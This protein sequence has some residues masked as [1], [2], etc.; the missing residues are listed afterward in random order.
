MEIVGVHVARAVAPTGET[1]IRVVFNGKDGASVVVDM[2]NSIHPEDDPRSIE[3]AKNVLVETAR[4][5]TALN[6]YDAQSNGNFDEISI[7]EVSEGNEDQIYIYEYRDGEGSTQ[8]PPSRM[9]SLKAAR[10]EAL[11]S[12]VD[13]LGDIKESGEVPSGWLVRVRGKGGEF[14]FAIDTAEAE[15]ARRF[16]K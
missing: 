6:D 11:R 14:L 2:A 5:K 12:A 10:E 3:R 16:G 4:Y 13:L 1:V 9:P 7:A 15:A 8:T